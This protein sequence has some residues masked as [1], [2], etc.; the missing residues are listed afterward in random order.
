MNRCFLCN[1]NLVPI[2]TPS[3]PN[4]SAARK[5]LASPNPPEA[6]TGM[7]NSSAARGTKINDVTSSSPGCPAHS[8]PSILIKS[9]PNAFCFFSYVLLKY[10]C[11]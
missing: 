3:A 8:K 2:F 1:K 6:I 11:E 5:P 4:A 10:I 7:F 9:Q